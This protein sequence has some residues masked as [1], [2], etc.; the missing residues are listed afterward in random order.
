MA[1]LDNLVDETNPERLL[2]VDGASGEDHLHRSTV[3][4][5]ARQADR[6]EID[7]RH[8]EASVALI[9]NQNSLMGGRATWAMMLIGFAGL[10]YA[11]YRRRGLRSSLLQV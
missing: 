1:V 4:D 7:E 3:A 11:G 10:S 2:G 5:D 6:T 9:C 8:A